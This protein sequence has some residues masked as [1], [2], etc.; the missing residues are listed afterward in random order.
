MKYIIIIL[1]LCVSVTADPSL[2]IKPNKNGITITVSNYPTSKAVA[3]LTCDGLTGWTLATDE[4]GA[5]SGEGTLISNTNVR[6]ER[7]SVF[8]T[9]DFEKRTIRFFTEYER[10]CV[11]KDGEIIVS[12]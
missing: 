3:L 7:D 11:L 6:Y 10:E 1:A 5:P 2:V 8:S 4:N 9:N 12:S